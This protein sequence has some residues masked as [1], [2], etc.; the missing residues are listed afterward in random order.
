[1][2]TKQTIKVEVND[3]QTGMYVC[4]LDRPWL[5]TPYL[6]QEILIQSQDDIEKLK[7]YCTLVYVDVDCSVSDVVQE[8][9]KG[10]VNV[11]QQSVV[12]GTKAHSSHATFSL[13]TILCRTMT[14]TDSRSVEH[15]LPAA[16]KAYQ[17]TASIFDD[18]SDNIESNVKFDIRVAQDVVNTLCE[19]II[20]NPD[21]AMLMAQLKVTGKELYDNAI[22]TSVHL[23]AFGR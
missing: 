1:M 6:I 10:A 23:L 4:E 16:T 22:K 21:A 19:S 14:Y 7:R 11:T 18:I 3:L 5:E 12:S 20:R 2:N 13:D 8:R 9:E 15:E 17:A